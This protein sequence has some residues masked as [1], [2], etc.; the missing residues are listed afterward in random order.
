MLYQLW[1]G[2]G[3][4]QVQ[5]TAADPRPAQQQLDLFDTPSDNRHH[6]ND[7]V[8][9]INARFGK[10]TIAPARLLTQAI[11]PNVIAP[12]FRPTGPRQSI[13]LKD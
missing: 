1:Q 2:Q 9:N 7:T 13:D 8:D 12:A 10:L 5:I 4:T 11:G 6:L 3:I